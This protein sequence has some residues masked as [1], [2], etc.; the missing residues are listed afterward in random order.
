MISVFPDPLNLFS[1]ELEQVSFHY[2]C[3]QAAKENSGKQ[4]SVPRVKKY[5]F[6]STATFATRN[7]SIFFSF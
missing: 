1:S 3:V 6:K 2:N 5:T 4:S 7:P